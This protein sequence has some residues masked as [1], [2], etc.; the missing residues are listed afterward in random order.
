MVAY[1]LLRELVG[2]DVLDGVS[3]GARLRS[4]TQLWFSQDIINTEP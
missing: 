2:E 1:E 3:G 4:L